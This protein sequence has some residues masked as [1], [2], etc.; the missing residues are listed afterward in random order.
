M[1]RYSHG[2]SSP[3][4]VTT[5]NPFRHANTRNAKMAA[6][7]YQFCVTVSIPDICKLKEARVD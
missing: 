7:S 1:Q 2:T 4:L 6:E 5:S 3:E